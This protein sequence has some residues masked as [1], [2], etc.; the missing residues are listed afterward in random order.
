MQPYLLVYT[1]MEIKGK[2][3]HVLPLQE[4]VSRAGNKWKKREYVL[5]TQEQ[6]PRKVCFDFFGDKVDQYPVE[7]GDDVTLSFDIES[8]EYNGRWYTGIHGWKLEKN[9]APAAADVPPMPSV[10]EELPPFPT[11]GETGSD[12][13]PF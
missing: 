4:G 6:Y 11:S 9:S 12:D 5:E 1:I 2:I 7:I 13:L 3:I 10:S 8:R